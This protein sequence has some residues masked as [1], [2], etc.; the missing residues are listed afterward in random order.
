MEESGIK[1][2]MEWLVHEL[3]R[4][5][6]LYHTLDAPE[7]S[8][9]AYDAL[10]RE[11][12]ALEE[13]RP[14]LRLPD[15]PTL[16][17]GGGVLPGLEKKRHIRR[18]YGLDN[19]FSAEEW[20]A[21]VD[22][23]VRA[24]EG[25][26][27]LVL[28]FWCDPKL[29]GLALEL[30]YEKG[31]LV[32]ALTRGDGE[33]GEVVTAQARAIRNIP[34]SLAGPGPFPDYI[35]VRGEVVI[36][37]K[38]FE[39]LNE[40][41][42]ELGQKIFSNPRNAAA[43]ALRQLDVS[44]TRSRPLK[45]LAYGLGA[46]T[47]G[48]AQP[49]QTQAEAVE[50]FIL[51]G[52]TV[53]PDGRLCHGVAGVI[54]YA[55]WVREHRPEFPMEIDGAVAKLNS[56]AAQEA[57]GFTARAPRFAIA[58]K[59]PAMEAETKLL[60]IGIQVGRTGVLTPVAILEPVPVGG[61]VVSRATLHNEDEIRDKDLRIGDTVRLR[62][63]GDVIP[64]ILGVN[65]EK[66]PQDAK[67]YEFPQIC[68]VCGAPALREPGQAAR[69]CE[70]MACPAMNLRSILHFVSPAGLDVIGIG[71]KW[72]ARLV[73]A[74]LVKSPADLFTL[75]EKDLLKFEGMG[76]TLA[77]KFVAA[78][79]EAGRKA[80]LAKLIGALGIRHV[81][82]QTA[83]GLASRFKSLDALAHAD[84]ETLR[85]VPDVGPEVAASIRHF[86]TNPANIQ[87]LR[88]LKDLGIWPESE[89]RETAGSGPLAGKSILFTGSL[90][91][92][93][94]RAQELAREAGADVK[95]GVSKNLDFLVAGEKAGSKLEKAEKLG[96][97]VITEDQFMKMLAESGLGGEA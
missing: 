52:F 5:N 89:E 63:A 97:P 1:S 15:S 87:V 59:F 82:A 37:K 91:M 30:A 71:E 73:E 22:R 75:T 25:A 3:N 23:L 54:D 44:V 66:R 13:A 72:I 51:R 36:Y 62:R 17:I 14:D 57:L 78:L 60:D 86:F 48:A 61:V 64:E 56:L 47:W 41:Q 21:F 7:I 94:P 74:G 19:V 16:R 90:S 4:H 33:E 80:T 46:V 93:R 11:L 12:L 18:M 65:L 70:N 81:G 58:F 85:E 6:R 88:K 42:E 55:E 29:D 24:Y 53:P 43:G 84:E 95:S 96:V 8:D 35:E 28:D 2:R 38:D 45:F 77:A 68:P 10:F 49:C 32:Q 27:E 69:R 76:E 79:E 39:R 31:L 40:R 50:R 9:D 83:R 34:L 67:P 92:P 20:Q 26:D